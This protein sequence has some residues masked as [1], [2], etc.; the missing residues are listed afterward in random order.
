M[1][2]LPVAFCLTFGPNAVYS[3][4]SVSVIPNAV[5]DHVLL[6]VCPNAVYDDGTDL[7]CYYLYSTTQAFSD[8]EGAKDRCAENTGAT[9]IWLDTQ[10]KIDHLDSLDLFAGVTG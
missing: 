7:F 1:M 6:S 5:C 9:V 3:H 2:Q 8:L 10:A 4:P